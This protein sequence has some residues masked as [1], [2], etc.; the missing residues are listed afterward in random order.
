MHSQILHKAY[1]CC[2]DTAYWIFISVVYFQT[3]HI[4]ILLAD[5]V[6]NAFSGGKPNHIGCID[7]VY[8]Q[9]ELSYGLQDYYYLKKNCYTGF[10]YIAYPQCE[11]SCVL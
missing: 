7:M 6:K 5:E 9:C 2:I 3:P 4:V 8:P 11:L 1:I 10:I